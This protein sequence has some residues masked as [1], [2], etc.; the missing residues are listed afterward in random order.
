MK[1]MWKLMGT[2]GYHDEHEQM[3]IFWPLLLT[4]IKHSYMATATYGGILP[5]EHEPKFKYG[6]VPHIPLVMEITRACWDAGNIAAKHGFDE[7][8]RAMI[9]SRPVGY[10]ILDARSIFTPSARSTI[11]ADG[12]VD[13]NLSRDIMTTEVLA[14]KLEYKVKYN[15]DT[16]HDEWQCTPNWPAIEIV[17][18]EAKIAFHY[19]NRAMGRFGS[20]PDDSAFR[21]RMFE[22][23]VLTLMY[24]ITGRELRRGI[25]LEDASRVSQTMSDYD[26][27]Y[28]DAYK[29]RY[30]DGMQAIEA[31]RQK[32]LSDTSAD[33]T[34]HDRFIAVLKE[35][36]YDPH[37]QKEVHGQA[38]FY[39]EQY[40]RKRQNSI[41]LQQL[42][43][44]NCAKAAQ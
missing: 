5:S 3:R 44:T 34:K 10:T 9:A 32:T 39:H 40:V 38:N 24:Q 30:Q 42:A 2:R 22:T 20:P 36:M 15:P 4:I 26:V 17:I 7:A 23:R 1:V 18:G 25:K 8:L 28:Q 6:V 33:I 19:S 37:L 21:F 29:A 31:E 11:T 41:R 27:R 35:H 16:G 14:L 12:I 13:M 43:W